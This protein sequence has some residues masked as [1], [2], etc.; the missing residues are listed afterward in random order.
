LEARGRGNRPQA[1]MADQL[2]HM[3]PLPAGGEGDDD[4]WNQY[5]E[6]DGAPLIALSYVMYNNKCNT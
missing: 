1:A 5:E 2:A 4:H 6:D 3:F